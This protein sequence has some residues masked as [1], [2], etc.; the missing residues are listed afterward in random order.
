M[1]HSTMK[2]SAH[3]FQYKLDLPDIGAFE[4]FDAQFIVSSIFAQNSP[5]SCDA[6]SGIPQSTELGFAESH[7]R[8][9]PS[10]PSLDELCVLE[11]H[12][13]DSR[14]VLPHDQPGDEEERD[15]TV[16]DPFYLVDPSLFQDVFV[17][18]DAPEGSTS[19]FND[20]E[21]DDDFTLVELPS[22]ARGWA[23]Q[24]FESGEKMGLLKA[25]S[26]KPVL[27]KITGTPLEKIGNLRTAPSSS[28][29]N[30]SWLLPAGED[31]P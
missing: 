24:S 23:Q 2:T 3:V 9:N 13:N 6:G 15:H 14:A 17:D 29:L 11:T 20:E 10:R 31:V 7:V 1:D 19:D 28:S 30:V 12:K 25:F 16:P 21:G 4:A 8:Q 22:P 26:Q 5:G 27:R 18:E